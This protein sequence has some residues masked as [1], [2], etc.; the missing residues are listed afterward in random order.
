MFSLK[1]F[2][3]ARTN[4]RILQRECRLIYSYKKSRCLDWGCF[5][6]TCIGLGSESDSGKAGLI[7][8]PIIGLIDLK[9]RDK[10]AFVEVI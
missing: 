9:G 3:N 10:H 5:C 7:F 6:V 2:A 4:A 1:T 8:V